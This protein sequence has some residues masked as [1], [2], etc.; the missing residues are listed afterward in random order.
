MAEPMWELM[1]GGISISAAF[2]PINA[3][4]ISAQE[5]QSFL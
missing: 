4:M 3:V 1:S 5:M 2:L